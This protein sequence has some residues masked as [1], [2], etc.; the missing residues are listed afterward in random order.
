MSFINL[1][2]HR[3]PQ[4]PQEFCIRNAYFPKQME[5]IA[6]LGYKVSVGIHP[7]FAE[8]S[9]VDFEVRMERLLACSTVIAMGEIGLDRVKKVSFAKQIAIFEQQLFFAEKYK[10]PVILHCVNALSDIFPY[11]KKTSVPFIF[12]QFEGNIIQLKQLLPYPAFFSFGKN[13]FHS[14]K[15]Q[16]VFRSVPVNRY[17]LETDT[18]NI[19]IEKV[20]EQ[21]ALLKNMSMEMVEKQ[22]FSTFAEHL[23]Q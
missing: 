5:S 12:H 6:D 18:A 16:E 17:F 3:K 2:T 19:R 8:T 21:A 14:P 1:H 23:K 9:V 20:Y 11:L 4:S 13:L 22:V 7:W 15:S 10:M